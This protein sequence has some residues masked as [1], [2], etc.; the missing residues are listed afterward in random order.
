[1]DEEHNR[2]LKEEFG[3]SILLSKFIF[4]LLQSTNFERTRIWFGI[5]ER[6]IIVILCPTSWL[7]QSFNFLN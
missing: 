3:K 7:E 6:E 2:K 1:L 4:M 5:L